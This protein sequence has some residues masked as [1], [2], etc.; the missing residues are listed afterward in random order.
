MGRIRHDIIV[1]VP[2]PPKP[3]PEAREWWARSWEPS[4]R[5]LRL[6]ALLSPEELAEVVHDAAV[7]LGTGHARS[8]E[9]D[10]GEALRAQKLEWLERMEPRMRDVALRLTEDLLEAWGI[11]RAPPP[12][13]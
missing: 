10:P 4:Y 7:Q 9:G 5:E 11:F 6:D 13:T 12:A 8:P 3:E 2:G 1:V